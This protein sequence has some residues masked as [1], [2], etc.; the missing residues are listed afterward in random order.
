MSLFQCE[1]CGCVENTALA[2]QGFKMRIMQECFDWTGIEDR[3]N[4]LLCSACGPSRYRD[5]QPSRF[6]KWH[7]KFDRVF[8][9][10]DKFFT[11]SVGN[12]EHKETG[13][14]DYRQYQIT[15]ESA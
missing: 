11:N 9:P 10:K 12:L 15:G 14:E 2:A 13:S 7:E 4:K 3:Q 6:G 1:R 8:L 5:G